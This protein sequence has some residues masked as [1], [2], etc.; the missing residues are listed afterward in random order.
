MSEDS[1]RPLQLP[2]YPFIFKTLVV[3]GAAG[4]A[5]FV[6]SAILVAFYA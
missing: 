4:C 6:V 1:N 2:T 3:Y 5:V